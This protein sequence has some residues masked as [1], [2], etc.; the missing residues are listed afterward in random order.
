[1]KVTK[2]A[3]N[4]ALPSIRYFNKWYVPYKFI[5]LVPENVSTLA[6]VVFRVDED[7][8]VIERDYAIGEAREPEDCNIYAESTQTMQARDR[9]RGMDDDMV[10]KYAEAYGGIYT[11]DLMRVRVTIPILS[12]QTPEAVLEEAVKQLVSAGAARIICGEEAFELC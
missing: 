7:G 2:K 5:G 4:K 6:S 1:M 11:D 12:W 3:I 8:D 9:A 10:K